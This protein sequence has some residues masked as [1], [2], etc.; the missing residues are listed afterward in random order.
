[1]GFNDFLN[2]TIKGPSSLSNFQEENYLN[3]FGFFW[4]LMALASPPSWMG[5]KAIKSKLGQDGF[6]KGAVRDWYQRL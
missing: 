5:K 1:M 6:L 3:Y 4:G 2:K